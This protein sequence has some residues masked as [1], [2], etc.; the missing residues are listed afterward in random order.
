MFYDQSAYDIR[1]EWGEHGVV[2]VGADCDVTII[3]D[4]LSFS[5]CVDIAISREAIVFP[6]RYKD[7]SA[8]E[9]AK[10]KN[11]LLAG[12]RGAGSFSLSPASLVNIPAETGLVLPSPNGATLTLLSQSRVTL[13][14]CLR[15]AVSVAKAAMSFGTKIAVIPAGERWPDGS[16]RP[17]LEDLLGAGAVISS[18]NGVKSPEAV[19]TEEMFTLAQKNLSERIR[20][21]SSGRE[22]VEKGFEE[23]V[24]LASEY[25]VSTSVPFYTDGAYHDTSSSIQRRI[26]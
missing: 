8:A 11:A 16:L 25:D 14:A 15:N 7:G 23:D 20:L 22:L 10:K 3:V 18:L 1:C 13:T 2:E 9:Y 24:R 12:P 4:V 19:A 5:T 26:G 6:Y 21:C 17:S